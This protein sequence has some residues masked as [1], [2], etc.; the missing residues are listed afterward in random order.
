MSSTLTRGCR[1]QLRLRAGL[2][3]CALLAF[4]GPRVFAQTPAGT[5]IVSRTTGSYQTVTGAI[6]TFGDSSFVVVGQV[7]GAGVTPPRALLGDAGVTSVIGHTLTNVGNGNDSL[8]VA[9]SS[10][11]GWPTRIYRDVNGNGVLDPGDALLTHAVF[12]AMQASAE[13]LVT[14]DVPATAAVRGLIDT[15]DVVTVSR[16]DT[17]VSASL[18][19][20]LTIRDAGISIALNKSA[21]RP[22]A[23]VGDLI[24][25][26]ITFTA[27]G[28]GSA[29]DFQIT[30]PIPDGASYVPSTM[31]LNGVSLTDPDGDDAGFFDVPGSRV[32]FR[33]ATITAGQT[34]TV[35]FQ[36]RVDR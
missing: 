12:L 28:S 1:H 5:R 19:D 18:Y 20:V 8:A 6:F 32:I 29:T 9:A 11:H 2:V 7:A 35:T 22:S 13:I 3:L 23:A 24:T 4:S 36:V 30:D 21:N 26:S 17:N 25:Y 27:S 33:F 10:R 34:G 31:R 16:Y 14:V 15:V